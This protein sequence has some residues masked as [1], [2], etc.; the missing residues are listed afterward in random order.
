M[1][2][3]ASFQEWLSKTISLG[4]GFCASMER[5]DLEGSVN[6]TVAELL[7][8]GVFFRAEGTAFK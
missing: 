1:S 5:S 2:L 6:K 3:T 8:T 4:L 7:V